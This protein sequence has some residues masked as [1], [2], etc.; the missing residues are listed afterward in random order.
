MLWDA[1]IVE[2]PFEGN[3]RIVM[4]VVLPTPGAETMTREEFNGFIAR[5]SSTKLRYLSKNLKKTCVQ[6]EI[7]EINLN[8]TYPVS[9]I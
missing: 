5:M 8:K 4:Y 9:E 1:E 6:V 7:P 3:D 2:L